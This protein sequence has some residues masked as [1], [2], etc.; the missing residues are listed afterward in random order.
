MLADVD[1]I[2]TARVSNQK[3]L[4]L[5]TTGIGGSDAGA[6]LGLNKYS[7]PLSVYLAKKN[8]ISE[9]NQGKTSSNESIRWGKMAESAIRKGIADDLGLRIEE[10]P[11]M[12]RSREERKP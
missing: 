9:E 10:V 1:F 2:S 7:S 5:R 8:M 4:N 12:F 3:W 11:G 6:I